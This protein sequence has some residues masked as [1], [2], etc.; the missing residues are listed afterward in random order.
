MSPIK[1]WPW[2]KVGLPGLPDLTPFHAFATGKLHELHRW[3]AQA[4]RL[5]GCA[6]GEAPLSGG[7][8]EA[9]LSELRARRVKKRGAGLGSKH[10]DSAC[11]PVGRAAVPG[12]I[13][14]RCM[15]MY[16]MQMSAIHV[17]H[18]VTKPFES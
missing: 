8:L 12:R 15:A 3:L 6:A 13:F 14:A 18:V 5:T 2:K 7:G 10:A 9:G 1:D 4:G 16:G 17:R 11:S